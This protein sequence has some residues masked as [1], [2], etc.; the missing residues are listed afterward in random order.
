MR[1]I[2]DFFLCGQAIDAQ[3]QVAFL[4][5]SHERLGAQSYLVLLEPSLLQVWVCNETNA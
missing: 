1:R 2:T 3:Y 4:M 5:G